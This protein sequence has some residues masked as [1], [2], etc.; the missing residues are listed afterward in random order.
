VIREHQDD[1]D[2]ILRSDDARD[3]FLPRPVFGLKDTSGSERN[4]PP[5]DQLN[6]GSAAERDQVPASLRGVPVIHAAGKT[7]AK[8]ERLW[9]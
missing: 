9:P 1:R 6:F 4:L 2:P 8:T 3:V 5:A 7:N